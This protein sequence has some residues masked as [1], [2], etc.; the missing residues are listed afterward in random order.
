MVELLLHFKF[1]KG[2]L[3]C[4]HQANTKEQPYVDMGILQPAK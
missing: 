3:V 1:E 2:F 4:T